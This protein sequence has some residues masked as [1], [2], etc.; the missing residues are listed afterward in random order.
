[1]RET[2][3]TGSAPGPRAPSPRHGSRSPEP[4]LLPN[5]F[6]ARQIVQPLACR[7]CGEHPTSE[8]GDS[9]TF[10][11]F[12]VEVKHQSLK[13]SANPQN[14]PLFKGTSNI[15]TWLAEQT[16]EQTFMPGDVGT[17]LVFFP[18]LCSFFFS[19]ISF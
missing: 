1:M 5:P 16:R 4:V 15:L 11:Y 6:Q 13:L 18:K 17:A 2:V 9:K 19:M 7:P 3:E 12:K 14:S 10:V 8:V